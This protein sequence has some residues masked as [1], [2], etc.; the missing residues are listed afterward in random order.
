MPRY[1]FRCLKCKNVF[2]YERSFTDSKD[3]P[4][5]DCGH[6]KVEKLIGNLAAALFKGS[7]FTKSSH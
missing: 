2:E 7:G 3:P 4:C 6:K 5:P 1:D